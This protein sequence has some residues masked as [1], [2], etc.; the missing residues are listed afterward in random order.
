MLTKSAAERAAVVCI[1]VP[2]DVLQ[3]FKT[4]H[5]YVIVSRGFFSDNLREHI[6]C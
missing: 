4:D 2:V 1:Y 6:K 5:P 3:I